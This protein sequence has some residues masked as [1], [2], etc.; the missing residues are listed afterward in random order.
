MNISISF[1]WDKYYKNFE[2]F[3]IQIDDTPFNWLIR[4]LAASCPDSIAAFNEPFNKVSPARNIFSEN[5]VS[6]GCMVVF[7]F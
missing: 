5:C 6:L 2:L 7:K 1:K 3:I 4:A